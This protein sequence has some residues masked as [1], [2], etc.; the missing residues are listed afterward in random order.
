MRGGGPGAALN[1]RLA[2]TSNHHSDSDTRDVACLDSWALLIH[3][4][5]QPKS[6]LSP[7]TVVRCLFEPAHSG[8]IVLLHALPIGVD[9]PEVCHGS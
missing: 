2:P 1:H 6:T 5:S 7:R 8:G 3:H 9:V 4:L